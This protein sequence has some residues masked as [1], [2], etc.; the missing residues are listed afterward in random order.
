[1][2]EKLGFEIGKDFRPEPQLKKVYYIYLV[3]ILFLAI[4]PWYIPVL[5]FSPMIVSVLIGTVCLL[6]VLFVIYWI[7]RYYDSISYRMTD[8][9][10][11]WRRGVWFRNTGIVPFDRITNV[12]ISQGPISRRLGIGT[13]KI[14]TA[15]YSTQSSPEINIVGVKNF[16]ELRD[17]IMRFVERKEATTGVGRYENKGT[18]ELILDEVIKI[19]KLLEERK[20]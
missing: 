12:D 14:Q 2:T 13:L 5:I 19:R 9:E 16:E 4:L 18:E 15:G 10:I 1:M 17:I 11:I 20:L 8:R 7:G 6:I 3:L